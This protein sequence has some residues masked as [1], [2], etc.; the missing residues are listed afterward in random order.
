MRLVVDS[1]LARVKPELVSGEI[2]PGAKVGVFNSHDHPSKL[3]NDFTQLKPEVL[4]IDNSLAVLASLISKLLALTGNSDS[5][6]ILGAGNVD[7]IAKIKASHH[8]FFDVVSLNDPSNVLAANLQRI[9]SGKSTLDSDGLWKRIPR[10]PSIGDISKVAK[11]ETDFSI[12]ELVCVG[13]RDQDIAEVLGYSVQAIKNR[14]SLM[15]ARAGSPNR[16][17]LASQFTSQL[18][19]SRMTDEIAARSAQTNSH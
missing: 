7:D 17:Q 15:L 12:L 13:L 6:L 10:P 1:Y 5:R 9:R 8:G 11:D 14:V 3:V 18:L 19:T 4:V 16:T 2:V